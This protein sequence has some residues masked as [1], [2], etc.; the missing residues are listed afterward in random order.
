MQSNSFKTVIMSMNVSTFIE[1]L[2]NLRIIG[3]NTKFIYFIY[4]DLSQ[5]ESNRLHTFWK[6]LKVWKIVLCKINNK[7]QCYARESTE[8]FSNVTSYSKQLFV[9]K[10]QYFL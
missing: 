5:P 6:K 4:D 10:F 8:I 1:S 7:I 9:T 3:S 2:R